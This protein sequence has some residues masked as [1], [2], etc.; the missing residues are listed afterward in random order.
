VKVDVEKL[1]WFRG[2]FKEHRNAA[3]IICIMNAGCDVSAWL[4]EDE[5]RFVF[6]SYG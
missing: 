2:T 5:Y 3:R 4:S 6:K 1:I